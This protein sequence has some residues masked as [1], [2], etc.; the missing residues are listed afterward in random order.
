MQKIRKFEQENALWVIKKI[1]R[2]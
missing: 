1:E 2:I